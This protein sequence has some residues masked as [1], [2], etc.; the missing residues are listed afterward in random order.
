MENQNDHRDKHPG[1]DHRVTTVQ[2]LRAMF[3]EPHPMTPK[4]VFDA[5]DDT[6]TDFIKRSPLIVLG[7]ADGDGNLDASPKGDGPGF[8]AVVDPHTILIP[9]RKG[10]KLMY[11]LQNILATDKVGILFMVPGTDETLRVNGTAELSSDPA[12]LNLLVARGAPALLAIRVTVKECFFH[13][14]KAF[15]RSQLWAPETWGERQTISFGKMMAAKVGASEEVARQ[16]DQAVAEDY[17][18]NL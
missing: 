10:N 18:H 15:I 2:Q 8:V 4:K 12:L 11:G 7:T 17:K 1:D 16:V 3:G 14:A 9:E 13:C 6:M 5:L